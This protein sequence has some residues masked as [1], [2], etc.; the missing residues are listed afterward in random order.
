MKTMHRTSTVGL[1]IGIVLTTG[2]AVAL[3]AVTNTGAAGAYGFLFAG[4]LVFFAFLIWPE[5]TRF[6]GRHLQGKTR[7]R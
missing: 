1:A 6:R 7:P 4:M 5:R 2:G 3:T